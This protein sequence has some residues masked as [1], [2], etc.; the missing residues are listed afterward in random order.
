MQDVAQNRIGQTGEPDSLAPR[1]NGW[2][3]RV[4][5]LRGE[6]EVHVR[7]RLLEGLEQGVGGLRL[8]DW[9]RDVGFRENEE[10]RCRFE[11]GEL[12]ER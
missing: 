7:A 1:A 9:E 3:E 2:E 5:A 6:N 8:K 11:G 12:C 10:G 4:G